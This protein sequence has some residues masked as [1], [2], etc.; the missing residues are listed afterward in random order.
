MMNPV[1]I[2]ATFSTKT[3]KTS[4][5]IQNT[6]LSDSKFPVFSHRYAKEDGVVLRTKPCRPFIDVSHISL[7]QVF[8]QTSEGVGIPVGGGFKVKKRKEEK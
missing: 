7:F 5:I 1:P 4:L 8:A 2:V 6:T 3:P